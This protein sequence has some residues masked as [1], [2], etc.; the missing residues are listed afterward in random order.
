MLASV[1]LTNYA[2]TKELSA[3][4][5]ILRTS[6]LESLSES[7]YQGHAALQSAEGGN[8]SRPKALCLFL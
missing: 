4:Q 7:V 2:F 3:I 8:L 5:N 1:P 6:L